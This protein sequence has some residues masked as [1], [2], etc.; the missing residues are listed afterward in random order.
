[1]PIK[2]R[3]HKT[4]ARGMFHVKQNGFRLANVL[5]THMHAEV[6]RMVYHSDYLLQGFT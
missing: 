4:T 1:M 3:E 6:K 2:R 5:R